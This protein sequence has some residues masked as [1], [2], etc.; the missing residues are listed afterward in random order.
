MSEGNQRIV[1]CSTVWPR[2]ARRAVAGNR[3][4]ETGSSRTIVNA[5]GSFWRSGQ[6][7]TKRVA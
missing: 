3:P 7:V 1:Q 5:V 2:F 6:H 4:F